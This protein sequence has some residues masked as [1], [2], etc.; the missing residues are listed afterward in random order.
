[1]QS[2]K[3]YLE[4]FNT[5]HHK[6][7]DQIPN[8]VFFVDRLGNILFMNRSFERKFNQGL[9]ITPATIQSIFPELNFERLKQE[10]FGVETVS[11]R[12]KWMRIA[13]SKVTGRGGLSGLWVLICE[14]GAIPKPSGNKYLD[15]I[16][17]L[18]DILGNLTDAVAIISDEHQFVFANASFAALINQVPDAMMGQDARMYIKGLVIDGQPK[19]L[20]LE[21]N[22][23]YDEIT[24]FTGRI[25]P[26][27]T[28]DSKLFL[29]IIKNNEISGA[30]SYKVRILGSKA[31][32][33]QEQLKRY[34]N[35]N[36]NLNNIIGRSQQVVSLKETLKKISSTN[37][38][39]LLRG[40]NGVG[41]SLAAQVLHAEGYY[42][43]GPFITV[44][45]KGRNDLEQEIELFGPP[46]VQPKYLQNTAEPVGI[47]KLELANGG[48]LYIEDVDNLHYR[49]QNR[50]LNFLETKRMN[51][52]GKYKKLDVRVVVSTKGNMEEL[53]KRGDFREDLYFRLNTISLCIPPLRDRKEDISLLSEYFLKKYLATNQL[54]EQIPLLAPDTL[55]S[56]MNYNWPGNIDELKEVIHRI[57]YSYEG[58]VVYP[59]QLP[60]Y[61]KKQLKGLLLYQKKFTLKE[62][63]DETEK[64]LLIQALQRTSGNKV[65]AAKELGISRA[66]LYQ[67]L[68]KYALL[69]D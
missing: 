64:N 17:M 54:P 14:A 32:F 43:N 33:L 25:Y 62:L 68:E 12:G 36:Y 56:L 63:M 16:S 23:S 58:S 61:I 7:L 1:M 28:E 34:N 21:I 8:G 15:D 57:A 50:L 30:L 38:T 39:V 42:C 6:L 13:A 60:M 66:G 67:K 41:K 40:E 9:E 26:I 51:S 20:E 65:K 45:L 19:E 5:D 31:A 48:T 59:E 47:G 18:S 53:V 3:E 27:D 22:D 11:Y 49:L 37:C 35:R 44:E 2:H 69:D 46:Q 10:D 29:V 52:I 24:A 55:K 4:L